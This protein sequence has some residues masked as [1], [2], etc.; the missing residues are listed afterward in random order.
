MLR[1]YS[2]SALHATAIVLFLFVLS[3]DFYKFVFLLD[4]VLYPS[5]AFGNASMQP[6]S[7]N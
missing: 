4:C 7:L 1:V 2:L 6:N 3:S 5:N